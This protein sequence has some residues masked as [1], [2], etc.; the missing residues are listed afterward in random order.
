[1]ASNTQKTY[2]L[3][4]GAQIPAI[5]LGTWQDEA[6]QEAS[7]LVALQTGYRHIDTAR[8][9]GTEAAVGK[10]IQKSG[11]NRSEI[12]VTSKL[13]NNKHHP[14]DVAQALQDSLDD[15]GLEYLDL[16][17]MHWPCAFKRGD[18][19]FPSDKDGKL[20]TADI[21]YVDTYKA[22]E[23]LVKSGKAKAIGVCNFSR[24]EIERLIANATIKPAV[25]QME[26]HPWLQQSDFY[27]FHRTHGIHVTQYSPFGD[28]NQIYGAQEKYGQL[29]NDETLVEIGK[30]YGKTSAQVAL[31]W[32]IEHGRSVIPKSKHPERIRQNFDINFELKPEDLKKISSI[33]R[34][35]R[36]NDSSKDFGYELFTDLDG[37]QK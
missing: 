19:P 17:L 1:M 12:F 24:K 6:A 9:Y 32:G 14:D 31:V 35:L 25:H 8:C 2:K 27:D 18:D 26:L 22:M 20:I 28:Q 10:A 5:G 11:I 7:V 34:K 13:W 37:K 4:T 15:L 29:I 33:D 30:K 3:S 36:F 23:D 16:F 21:D